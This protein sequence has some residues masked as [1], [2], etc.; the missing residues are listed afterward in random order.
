MQG[1]KTLVLF[2]LIST[3]VGCALLKEPVY[4]NPKNC[5]EFD[6]KGYAEKDVKTND[7]FQYLT[8]V[9]IHQDKFSIRYIYIVQVLSP[10]QALALLDPYFCNSIVLVKSAKKM[11]WYDED[12]LDNVILTNLKQPFTYTTTK[13]AKKTVRTFQ[14][15]RKYK[16]NSLELVGMPYNRNKEDKC[17]VGYSYK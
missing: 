4:G 11:D 13:K 8:K 15:T 5:W 16:D 1:N 9:D 14:L 17:I 10:H 7:K 6:Y 12:V 2:L 3:L